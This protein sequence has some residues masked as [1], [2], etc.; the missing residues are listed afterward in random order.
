MQLLCL[1][2]LAL[3]E[4][5]SEWPWEPPGKITVGN[6]ERVLFNW[7]LPIGKSVNPVPRSRGT[8]LLAH[9]DSPRVIRRWS[10]GFASLATN[11]I[12]DAGEEGLA[13]TIESLNQAGFIT[14]GA[15]R[16]QE[17]I[18][19]PLFWETTE[20][21]LVVVNWVFPETHPDWNSVPGPNCWPGLEGAK[22]TIQKLK[23]EANWVLVV[24]HW[25]DE[26]F[27]YPRPEDRVIARELAQM[28]ADMV[29]GHHPHVVRGME[30]IEPCPVFYSI[31]NFCFSDIAN[32][33]GG[34]I[35]R[36]APKNRQ[37]LGVQIAFQKG[38]RPMYKTLSFVQTN[39]RAILDSFHRAARMVDRVSR[40]LQQ[41]RD[42]EYD[43]WYKARRGHFDRWGGRW[44]FGVRRL[45]IRGTIRSSFRALR[46]KIV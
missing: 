7:E 9:R 33:N 8:R 13:T 39:N 36:N 2:D 27:S 10:P 22:R 25:S 31:G 42:S 43:E 46:S 41:L 11:H 12:L 35:V 26:H 1:G 17:E 44:H 20:G 16:T 34:W 4:E 21:R 18:T 37:G 19:R 40:P 23:I 15:G 38:K 6:E 32:G 14:V 29:V 3:A 24:V 30:I 5:I 28:G 45:G